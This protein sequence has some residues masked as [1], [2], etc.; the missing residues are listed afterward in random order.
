[1]TTP[2][3]LPRAEIVKINEEDEIVELEEEAF[4]G[5]DLREV[6][7]ALGLRAI[8][9]GAD[10]EEVEKEGASNVGMDVENAEIEEIEIEESPKRKK[11]LSTKERRKRKAAA[12]T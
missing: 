7:E 6:K 9:Q 2:I 12:R 11:N 4:H 8:F 5:F 10:E 1:M 3:I